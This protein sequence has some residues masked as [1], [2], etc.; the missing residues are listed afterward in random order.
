MIKFGYGHLLNRVI[1]VA[2][3]QPQD[4]LKKLRRELKQVKNALADMT[5]KVL[6]T[7][8]MFDILA[9]ECGRDSKEAKKKLASQLHIES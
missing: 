4:E 3:E 9:E 2:N 7:E 5:V 1:I 8:N 6:V